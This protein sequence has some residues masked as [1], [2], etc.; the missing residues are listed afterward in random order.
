MLEKVS[1]FILF[2]K[3]IVYLQ[4]LFINQRFKI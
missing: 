2:K 3:K 4:K 1:L